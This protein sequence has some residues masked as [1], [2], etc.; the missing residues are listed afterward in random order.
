M[1]EEESRE[2]KIRILSSCLYMSFCFVLF[3][4]Q[5]NDENVR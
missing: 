4:L 2:I 5:E 1:N 3:Y